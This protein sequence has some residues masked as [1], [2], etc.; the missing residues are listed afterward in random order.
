M[1]SI[2][3][4]DQLPDPPSTEVVNSAI[5]LFAVSLPLQPAK[6]QESI[7]EQLTT[8]LSASAL[9]R[10]PGR[11]AAITVNVAIALLATVKA[12]SRDPTLAQGDITNTAVGKGI[13]DILQ[14][15]SVKRDGHYRH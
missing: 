8:H 13:R 5:K 14:V 2:K 1:R 12:S 3:N 4:Q 9:H 7:L 10:D 11:K 6:I 15:G